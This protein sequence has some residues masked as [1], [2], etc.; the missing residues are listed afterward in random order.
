MKVLLQGQRY[1]PA[2]AVGVGLVDEVAATPEAMLDA[3]RAWIKANPD[4][5]PAVGRRGLPDAGRHAV[6]R[7]SSPACC[8]RSRPTCASSSRA[9]RCR[10][11]TT[12]CA[13]RSRART[14]T[15]TPRSPIEGRYFVNLAKGQVAKNMIQAFWFDLN[16]I[17]AG[18]SRPDGYE[19]KPAQ[20]VAVL[21]AGMM[22]AGIAYVSARNGIE[23]V[24]KDVSIEAAEK[25]KAYSQKILDKA[26]VARQDDAGQGR[27]GARPHHADRRL[28][29]PRPAATWSSRPSSRRCRSSTRCSARP[30]RS[31]LP[32][33]LLGSNTS[34]LPITG[35]AEGVQRKAGLHRAALLLAGRQDAAA[36]DHPRRA[37]LRR[38]AGPRARLRASRS[39]RRRSSSTTA[40]ASSPR[41][42]IGTFV[43]EALAM[44]GEGVAPGDDRAGDDAGRVPGRRAAA[45]GRAQPGAVPED[46]QRD[47]RGAGRRV[48]SATRPR[49]I[50]EKMVELGPSRAA[51]GRRLLR[52][53]RVR[54]AASGCGPG[55]REQ[56]PV[57]GRP[58]RR[59]PARA[60]RADAGHRV[61]RVGAL[62]RGGR[63]DH[64]GRRQHRLDHGHR[65]PA[66]DRRRAAVH[67]RVPGR[68][69]P[70]FV[71]RADEFASRSTARASSRTRCCARRPRTARRS[72]RARL[73][74]VARVVICAASGQS[75]TDHSR[76]EVT[77]RRS[78][79]G[80]RRCPDR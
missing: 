24:L 58:G 11:R 8:R 22:G 30:S 53:R 69:R 34:T 19:P 77:T 52:L 49:T 10:R 42:V 45:G 56:F 62:R 7:R 57:A 15:S 46:P 2:D 54:Q 12:S 44:L 1:N 9:P 70:A 63:A 26:V 4:G 6:H 35:L 38:R 31:S 72:S 23:V 61:G 29:R 55:W 20:K 32:D 71:A 65:L 40:A 48:R 60:V 27:R 28:R 59:R 47:P 25:G 50:V 37:D 80:L 33:A 73:V 5:R 51:Q 41:A 16:S 36:R 66:V 67:Q 78:L 43:N 75:V 79:R 64:D 17:N 76:A 13:R 39:R 74:H 3:A 21:G 18:G 14:S 68:G